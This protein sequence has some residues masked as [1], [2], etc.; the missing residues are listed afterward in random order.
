M[1]K[2]SLGAIGLV[3]VFALAAAAQAAV[4]MTRTLCI[5][6]MEP[7]N[8]LTRC[9]YRKPDS[10][11]MTFTNSEGKVISLPGTRPVKDGPIEG[12]NPALCAAFFE[13][14][15][16]AQGKCDKRPIWP[17]DFKI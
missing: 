12:L 16:K 10:K 9:E 17:R 15:E 11:A 6:D 5:T 8:N 14:Q 4:P 2:L 7:E 13:K 3:G 1:R